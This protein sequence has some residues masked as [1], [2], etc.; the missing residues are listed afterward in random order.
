ML[1]LAIARPASNGGTVVQLPLPT[2]RFARGEQ[3]FRTRRDG[4][5]EAR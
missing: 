4:D 3:H 5:K 2:P 1:K